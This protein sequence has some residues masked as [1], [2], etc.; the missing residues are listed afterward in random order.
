MI[1]CKQCQDH[2]VGYVHHELSPTLH[3]R[4]SEHL[5]GCESCYAA[6]LEHKRSVSELRRV[7]PMVSS[8]RPPS[9]ERVWAA[10][11]ADAVRR[12]S[13]YYPLRYGMVMLAISVLLLMPFAFGRTSQ[14]LAEPPTQPA[15]LLRVTPSVTAATDTGVA[16]AYKISQTPAPAKLPSTSLPIDVI[17]T[18]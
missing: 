5:D 12:T 15:P 2:L 17:S 7:I 14:V 8:G 10:A 13:N 9:F 3:R 1:S 11:S 18:P 6:F 16:V 4:V